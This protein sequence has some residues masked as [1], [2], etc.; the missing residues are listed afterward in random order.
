MAR[1]SDT[2]VHLVVEFGKCVLLV[3]RSFGKITNGSGLNNIADHVPFDSLILGH[4]L[5]KK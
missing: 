2:V 5:L 3:N 1:G 4:L